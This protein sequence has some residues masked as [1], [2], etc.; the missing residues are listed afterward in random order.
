MWL[1]MIGQTLYNGDRSFWVRV[2]GTDVYRR[3]A[4]GNGWEAVTPV[5][6]GPVGPVGP[7]ASLSRTGALPQ[8]LSGNIDWDNSY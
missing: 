8:S 3:N 6:S 4:A 1:T 7:G 2:A 5:V